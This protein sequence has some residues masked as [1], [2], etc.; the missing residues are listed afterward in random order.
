MRKVILDTGRLVAL[1]CPRDEH[2][3][4]A[5][6]V[7]AELAPGSLICEAVL[8]EVCHL[9]AKESVTPG[10][11]VESVAA[12]RLIAVSLSNEL[13]PIANLLNRYADSPMDFADACVVRLAELHPQAA[14]CTLDGQFRF[15]RKNSRD[16]LLL[17]APFSS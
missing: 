12:G 15:F 16:P 8:T 11:V 9:V 5:R 13:V 6:R 2:Y 17:V 7:F 3:S 4:W 14:V 10:K 1:L